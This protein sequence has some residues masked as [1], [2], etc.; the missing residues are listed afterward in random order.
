MTQS[1]RVESGQLPLAL[2]M[3]NRS[4]PHVTGWTRPVLQV[5]DIL[6][7]LPPCWEWLSK[8]RACPDSVLDAH[9][10]ILACW[11]DRLWYIPAVDRGMA[12]LVDPNGPIYI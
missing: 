8:L 3:L 2:Y 9:L 7:I 4:S 6:S 10:F 12:S 5:H 1:V 11:V